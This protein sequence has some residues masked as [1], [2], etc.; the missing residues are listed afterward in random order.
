MAHQVGCCPAQSTSLLLLDRERA[1]YFWSK[2]VLDLVLSISALLFLSLVLLVI[3]LLVKLDSTGPVIFAQERVGA[4]RR[5][6]NGKEQWEIG[7]FHVFKFRTM[8]NNADQSLHQ[9]F[10]KAFIEGKV[11]GSEATAQSPDKRAFKLTRDPRITRVGALLRK[12]SLDELPQLVNVIRGEMS[13]VGPR[14]VPVYE[15]EGYK[16]WHMGRLAAIPGVTGMWQVYGRSRVAFEDAIRLDL[17]Y[18]AQQN[19]WLDIK[20]ILLTVPSVLMRRGAY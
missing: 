18:I 5:Q 12:T 1:L 15:V 6:V 2:R 16:P 8:V 14:P 9:A 10:I 7:T 20:I 11:E 13:L 3:A 17:D 19:L 4:R